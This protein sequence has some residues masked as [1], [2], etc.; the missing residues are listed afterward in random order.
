MSECDHLVG[1][2]EYEHDSRLR[3]IYASVMTDFL[4]QHWILWQFCP[5]CGKDLMGDTEIKR[6]YDFDKP[7]GAFDKSTLFA[8]GFTPLWKPPLRLIRLFSPERQ[9]SFRGTARRLAGAWR[10]LL[11]LLVWCSGIGSGRPSSRLRRRAIFATHCSQR[12]FAL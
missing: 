1:F 7:K 10:C 3:L 6:D 12:G 4:G 8:H 9:L 5:K 2:V 11:L